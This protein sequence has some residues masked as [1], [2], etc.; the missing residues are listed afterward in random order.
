MSKRDDIALQIFL[1]RAPTGHVNKETIRGFESAI[2][3]SYELA[4]MFIAFT[5]ST[6]APSNLYSKEPVAW[7]S[8]QFAFLEHAENGEFKAVTLPIETK[9]GGTLP[10]EDEL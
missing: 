6:C 10:P 9:V 8:P 7:P 3:Q 4:D 1:K 2:D 5:K